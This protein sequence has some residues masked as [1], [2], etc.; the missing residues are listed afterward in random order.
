MLGHLGGEDGDEK[1][2]AGAEKPGWWNTIS[3]K[4]A[5][6]I[7]KKSTLWVSPDVDKIKKEFEACGIKAKPEAMEYLVCQECVVNK[8]KA[9]KG[10][11]SVKWVDKKCKPNPIPIAILTQTRME[12]PDQD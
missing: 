3:Y 1:E 10:T 8:Y 5:G 9:D 7:Q 12:R 11:A 4:S 2:A 6:T